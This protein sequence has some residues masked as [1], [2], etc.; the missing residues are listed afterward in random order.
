MEL[1]AAGDLTRRTADLFEAATVAPIAI[2][3]HRKPRFV[4]MS[5]SQYEKLTGTE[6]A[7]M[8]VA[9]AD[10]PDDLGALLDQGLKDYLGDE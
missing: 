5:M 3:K 7:Q 10:M 4:V 9:V 8:A 2:T 6:E 1:F